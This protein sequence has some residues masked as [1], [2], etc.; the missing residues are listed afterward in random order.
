MEQGLSIEYFHAANDRQ[1]VRNTV[2]DVIRTHLKQLRIDSIIVE[3]SKTQPSLRG[4][5]KFYPKMIGYLLRYVFARIPASTADE[6]IVMTDRIP[7]NSK[8]RAVEKAVKQTL[9][10]M[11]PPHICYRLLHHDSKSSTGLQVAD[12]CNWAIYRW[13]DRED[14]RSRSVIDSAIKSEF[15]IFKSGQQAWY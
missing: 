8:R 12:Y 5:D 13:W 10:D 9:Q 11:V 14:N 1:H 2:F 6:I 3:K 7:L 4:E 15:D